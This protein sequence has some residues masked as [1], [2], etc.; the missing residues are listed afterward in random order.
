MSNGK[1]SLSV[2]G[3]V[4]FTDTVGQGSV[5][6]QAPSYVETS[7][8]IVLPGTGPADGSVLVVNSDGSSSYQPL[9]GGGGGGTTITVTLTP[10]QLQ[11]LN[12]SPVTIVP[13]PGAGQAIVIQSIETHLTFNSVPYSNAGDIALVYSTNTSQNLAVAATGNGYGQSNDVRSYTPGNVPPGQ[14]DLLLA[15]A[16]QLYSYQNWSNDGDSSVSVRV[17]YQT[18]TALT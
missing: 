7:Y 14:G 8:D 3:Q 13:A 9:P 2:P 1:V 15:T 4:T 18:L 16:V 6:L 5:S 10:S 11:N 12:S 17:T